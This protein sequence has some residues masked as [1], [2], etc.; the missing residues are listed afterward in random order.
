MLSDTDKNDTIDPPLYTN[1]PLAQSMLLHEDTRSASY[2][3]EGR[4][5]IQYPMS[6][7]GFFTTLFIVQGRA[8]D[9]MI[10]PW[11]LM[12]MHSVIYTILQETIFEGIH[13]EM[14]S[15]ELFYRCAHQNILTPVCILNNC[16]SD[17]FFIDLPLL[18]LLLSF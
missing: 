14:R 12:T 1:F 7:D 5:Q 2:I 17:G 13:R 9:W 15:W 4:R 11:T 6:T 3:Q 18:I 8:L 16:L 10:L